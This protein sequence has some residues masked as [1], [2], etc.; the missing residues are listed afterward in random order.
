[1]RDD[2]QRRHARRR[3]GHATA[4]TTTTMRVPESGVT[5]DRILAL[6]RVNRAL[7]RLLGRPR[8]LQLVGVLIGIMMVALA[9]RPLVW[10]T[11]VPAASYAPSS[12]TA[13]IP[14]P[15]TEPLAQLAANG[16]QDEV[17]NVIAAYNQASITA[18]VLGR[19]DPMAPYL[20]PDGSTWAE[21]QAEYQR[22]AT[23][24][25]THDPALSRWGVLQIVVDADIATVETQEQW[26]DM[27]S[28]GGQVVSSRRGMLTRNTYTLRR[29]PSLN[30]WLITDVATTTLI[31]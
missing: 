9:L 7:G 20:A 21:V 19:P 24:G 14:V 13:S 22:R 15:A 1:M 26:D 2:R 27:M 18:A 23:R 6:P 5:L 30:R 4:H 11:Q 17:L 8:A 25:E 16:G 10:Q 31:N 12:E 28:I 29:S 3:F